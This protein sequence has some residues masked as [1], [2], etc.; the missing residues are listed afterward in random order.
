M[1][2]KVIEANG[3]KISVTFKQPGPTSSYIEIWSLRASEEFLKKWC[4]L[5]EHPYDRVK[6]ILRKGENILVSRDE[7]QALY[8][9]IR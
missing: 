6:E 4:E 9:T 5:I 7:L 1:Y 2:L 3:E 8:N